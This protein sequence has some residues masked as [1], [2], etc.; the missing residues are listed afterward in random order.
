MKWFWGGWRGFSG[1][2]LVIGFFGI[3]VYFGGVI[4]Y[5]KFREKREDKFFIG[6]EFG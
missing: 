1:V 4:F 6:V 2:V 3:G 5:A